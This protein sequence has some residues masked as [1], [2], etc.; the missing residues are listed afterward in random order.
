MGIDKKPI[1]KAVSKDKK[2]SIKV[3]FDTKKASN[4]LKTK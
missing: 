3:N 1:E 4:G 2:I